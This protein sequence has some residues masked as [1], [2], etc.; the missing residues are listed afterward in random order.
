MAAAEVRGAALPRLRAAARVPALAILCWASSAC[1]R[2]DAWVDPR[3][4]IVGT[5][6]PLDLAGRP[7]GEWT[8]WYADGEVRERGEYVHGR[9]QG[10]FVQWYPEGQR[11][12][13][14]ERRFDAQ[15]R[16]SLREGPWR[17]WYANGLLR[18]VGSYEAGRPEGKWTWWNHEGVL[19]ARRS[20]IYRDGERVE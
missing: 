16:A 9:R 4:G 17:F 12:S 3:T 6:G 1:S 8:A 5:S 13:E 18:G 19:D 20:G 14:G 7:H 15:A 2:T 11:H 10:R